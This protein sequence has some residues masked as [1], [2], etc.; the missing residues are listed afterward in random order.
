MLGVAT[1]ALAGCDF[2]AVET[3]EQSLEEPTDPDSGTSEPDAGAGST[4]TSIDDSCTVTVEWW[5]G[6][7]IPFYSDSCTCWEN[8]STCTDDDCLA[9]TYQD[10]SRCAQRKWLRSV[11]VPPGGACTPRHVTAC[12]AYCNDKCDEGCAAGVES[13]D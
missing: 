3:V 6:N 12:A 8:R 10:R 4:L 11:A 7:P 2:T 9:C 5:G 1:V 13:A